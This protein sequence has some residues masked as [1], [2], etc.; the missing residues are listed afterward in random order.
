MTTPCIVIVRLVPLAG[1]RE[2]VVRLLRELIPEIQRG[3]GC[4]KYALLEAVDGD[5]VL[6]EKWSSREHWQAH[7]EWAPIVRLKKE[8]ADSVVLPVERL[9]TYPH[10]TG[11]DALGL[12]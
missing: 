9:E 3:P 12:I 11:D 4:E 2:A 5:V 7:F 10:P 8:L 1:K 6:I